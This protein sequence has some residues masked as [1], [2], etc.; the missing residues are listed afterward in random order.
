MRN[1][2][3]RLDRL[4]QKSGTKEKRFIWVD[5]PG[6]LERKRA[7]LQPDDIVI[8]WRWSDDQEPAV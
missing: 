6:D 2:A 5:S 1:I 3:R 4:E 8:R 7:E